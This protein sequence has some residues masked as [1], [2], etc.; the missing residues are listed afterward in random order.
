MIAKLAAALFWVWSLGCAVWV[1]VVFWAGFESQQ[2]AL[3]ETAAQVQR[4][5]ITQAQAADRVALQEGVGGVVG[6]WN[7]L[8]TVSLWAVPA[9]TLLVIYL[10]AR[11]KK[12]VIVEGS[13]REH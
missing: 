4:G 5:E 1:A 8:I 10:L 12:V 2:E 13:R 7:C 6:S 9:I 11:P 3:R